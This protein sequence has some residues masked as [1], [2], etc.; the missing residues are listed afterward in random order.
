MKTMH[1]ESVTWT[2]A[3]K[4]LLFLRSCWMEWKKNEAEMHSLAAAALLHTV[5]GLYL[6]GS[7]VGSTFL[8]ECFISGQP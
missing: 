8:K 2:E 5:C 4:L 3:L 7:R 6:K 1:P